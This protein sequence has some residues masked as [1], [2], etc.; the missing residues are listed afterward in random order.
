[1]AEQS[2]DQLPPW[3]TRPPSDDDSKYHSDS[4]GL[5]SSACSSGRSSGPE[6]TAAAT[7]AEWSRH[8]DFLGRQYYVH[9]TSGTRQWATAEDWI[10]GHDDNGYKYAYNTITGESQWVTTPEDETPAAKRNAHSSTASSGFQNAEPTNFYSI[11]Q[12]YKEQVLENHDYSPERQKNNSSNSTRPL[13]LQSPG[14]WSTSS[15]ASSPEMTPD[16]AADSTSVWSW[17]TNTESTSRPKTARARFQGTAWGAATA[18]RLPSEAPRERSA[19]RHSRRRARTERAVKVARFHWDS[20]QSSSTIGADSESETL[21]RALL[22]EGAAQDEAEGDIEAGMALPQLTTAAVLTLQ[23]HPN[24]IVGMSLT[25]RVEWLASALVGA[26]T[27]VIHTVAHH[28]ASAV[29]KL[30]SQATGPSLPTHVERSVMKQSSPS[31]ATAAADLPLSPS[32][33]F[34]QCEE[35]KHVR[36]QTPP[37]ETPHKLCDELKQL[38]AHNLHVGSFQPGAASQA[39]GAATQQGMPPSLSDGMP[40]PVGTQAPTG[41]A[42]VHE[43]V[44]PARGTVTGHGVGLNSAGSVQDGSPTGPTPATSEGFMTPQ[45]DHGYSSVHFTAQSASGTPTTGQHVVCTPGSVGGSS[46]TS[47]AIGCHSRMDSPP[48]PGMAI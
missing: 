26:S 45:R 47:A 46:A 23:Q 38:S 4:L 3:L 40:A 1:M 12:R 30:L 2:I 29:N 20:D 19:R 15:G 14:K 41:A 18:E 37:E 34:L 27:K 8:T 28:G 32:L 43:F 9:S 35:G 17:F 10:V 16:R 6:K 7:A 5:P 11:D 13:W 42:I 44:V 21:P 33:S 31:K 39:W 36:V 48:S 24:F 25:E 22:Y